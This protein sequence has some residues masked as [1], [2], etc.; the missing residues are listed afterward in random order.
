MEQGSAAERAEQLRSAMAAAPVVYDG[1]PIAVTASFGV[2]TLPGNGRTRDEL[3]VAADDALY[4][5]KAA[6]RNRVNISVK[7]LD[8]QADESSTDGH[9]FPQHRGDSQVSVRP[10]GNPRPVRPTAP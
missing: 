4:A 8:R 6:G 5:A 1:L 3:V 10:E 2:A 9:Q 7:H